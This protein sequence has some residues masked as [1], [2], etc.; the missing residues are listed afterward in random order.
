VYTTA[1]GITLALLGVL[2]FLL[3]AIGVRAWRRSRITPDEK[4][5]E[6]RVGLLAGG[7]RADAN[8]LDIQENVLIYSYAVRG[9]EYTASQDISRLKMFLPEDVA[10]LGPICVKYDPRNPANSIVLAEE[11]SGLRP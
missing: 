4:E 10:S 11:W 9:V 2:V 5:R 6:R 1:D 3:A 8:L 7:K